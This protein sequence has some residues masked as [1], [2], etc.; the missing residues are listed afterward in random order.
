MVSFSPC[1]TMMNG[2][3]HDALLVFGEVVA[4]HMYCWFNARR[5]DALFFGGPRGLGAFDLLGH[6]PV[7][8]LVVVV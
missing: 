3:V 1:L 2:V 5:C 6:G 8:S 4:R 7:D